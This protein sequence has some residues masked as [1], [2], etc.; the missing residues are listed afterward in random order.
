[1]IKSRSMIDAD[2]A[3]PDTRKANRAMGKRANGEGT[4]YQRNDGR[5]V[6]SISLDNGKRKT[7]YCK[8]QQAAIKA[9]RKVHNEKDQGVLL[10]AEDQTLQMF[11]T[12]WLQDTVRHNVR[13]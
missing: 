4:V 13:E 10:P 7:I 9:A 5:W 8:T 6:A 12:S 11:L 2:R 3:V 1:M